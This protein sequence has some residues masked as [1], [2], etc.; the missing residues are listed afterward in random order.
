MIEPYSY[1]VMHC[2]SYP[3]YVLLC[4]PLESGLGSSS[5]K[6]FYNDQGSNFVGLVRCCGSGEV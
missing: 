5:K 1:A 3:I 6:L 4:F 2:W